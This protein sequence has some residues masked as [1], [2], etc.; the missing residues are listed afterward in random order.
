MNCPF[1]NRET[2]EEF[3]EKHHLIPKSKKGKDTVLVCSDCGDMIHQLFKVSELKTKLNTVDK[4]KAEPK[5]QTWISWISKKTN[6]F[7]VCMARK[8]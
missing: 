1:C 5:M 2:P 4:I 8:K 7:G 3:Q 6:S